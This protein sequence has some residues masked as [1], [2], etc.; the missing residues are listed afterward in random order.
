MKLPKLDKI[1]SEFKP[2]SIHGS[3]FYTTKFSTD[4]SLASPQ[5][6]ISRTPILCLLSK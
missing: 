1:F 4:M 3:N 5:N 2:S 6:P